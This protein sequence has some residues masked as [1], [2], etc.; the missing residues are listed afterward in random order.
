[1]GREIHEKERIHPKI[2]DYCPTA[3]G[4]IA[5]IMECLEKKMQ[6]VKRCEKRRRN[7]E[8]SWRL[9]QKS[10]TSRMISEC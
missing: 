6:I 3:R 4:D 7:R 10:G 5:K 8:K 1:M 2:G 9:S